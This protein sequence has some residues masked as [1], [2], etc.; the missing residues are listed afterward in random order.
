MTLPISLRPGRGAFAVH[1][2]ADVLPAPGSL[3]PSGPR[4]TVVIPT[5]NEAANLQWVFDR[6]PDGLAEVIVVDA[7][8]TDGTV[9][10]ARALR[11]DVVV[12]QQSRRG[13]GNALACAFAIATGDILVMLDA[14]GSAH[15]AE[16]VRFVQALESGADFAKGSRFV[17]GGGSA[18]IT[19]L[20]R[21]GN[22]MLSGLVNR[23]FGTRYTDLCYG[24]NAFWAHCL[25][26]L[27]LPPVTGDEAV[28]G[29]GFEIETLINVR[30]AQSPLVVAEV[31]SFE[32]RRLH[33]V[34]NLNAWRDGWRVLR[35][36]LAE[37]RFRRHRTQDSEPRP[38][39]FIPYPSEPSVAELTKRRA[40]LA[41]DV[42]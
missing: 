9:E 41:E 40:V 33:G 10:S 11:D 36:I 32:S 6:L 1:H 27:D 30:V 14:D 17:T 8:S 35:V 13:K 12:V 15:P 21:A 31:A 39:A 38:R 25:P 20:R 23:C 19:R 26:Y 28:P 22:R 34:S 24:Y 4:V 42:A 16:I 2:P 18:D 5:K 3:D 7:Q 37:R 29:D